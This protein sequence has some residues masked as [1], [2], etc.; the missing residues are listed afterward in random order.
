M[1]EISEIFYSI[2][3]EGR[4]IGR[5]S[6]FVRFIGCNLNCNFCDSKYALKS[7]NSNNMTSKQIFDTIK[8]F[9]TN[10]NKKNVNIIF[11]GGEPMLYQKSI[12]EIIDLLENDYFIENFNIQIET[13]GTIPLKDERLRLCDFNISPKLSNSGNDLFLSINKKVIFEFKHMVYSTFKFVVTDESNF[14]E[15]KK[16]I[17][18]NQIDKSKVYIMPEGKTEKELNDKTL[19]IIEKCKKYGYNYTPRIHINIYGDK[20]GV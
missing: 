3:G 4:D 10:S 18:N 14:I 11:T 9:Y 19:W 13:N 5:P 7:N 2:Q 12:A 17:S 20:R 15:T 8:N 1:V 6:V 16:F